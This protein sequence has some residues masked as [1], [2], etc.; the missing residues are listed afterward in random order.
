[1]AYSS[2]H[3]SGINLERALTFPL[4][5]VSIPLSTAD[6]AIRKTSKS[7]L[8]DAS[9]ND[10]KTLCKEDFPRKENL[11][12]Y[13]LDL[14]AAIR[15][16][17]GAFGTIREMAAKIVA[18]V[19]RQYTTI[20][21][22]CDTYSRKSIKGGERQARGESERY[23]LASPDMT[24]PYD[25]D[26]FLKNGENKESLFNLIEQAIEEGREDHFISFSFCILTFLSMVIHSDALFY[27]EPCKYKT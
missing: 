24:V 16:L 5:P 25:F 9:M 22:V 6:G 12:T 7:K 14:A 13:F 4:A 15:S 26:K 17:V 1:M 27:R 10:L 11:K 2:K 21:I 19:P 3:E 20:Y 18:S 23:V 8:Y